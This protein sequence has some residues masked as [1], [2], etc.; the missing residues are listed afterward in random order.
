MIKK[1]IAA[2][3]FVMFMCLF[4]YC[5]VITF[6]FSKYDVNK[7]GSTDILDLLELQKHLINKK[8]EENK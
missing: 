3:L 5:F 8:S 1:I 6:C 7:N 2:I 4:I